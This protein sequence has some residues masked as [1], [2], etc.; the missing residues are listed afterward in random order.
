MTVHDAIRNANSLLPGTPV[1]VGEDPRWQA[2]IEIGQYLESQPQPVW[3]FICRWGA[4]PQ[5]DLRNAIASCLLEH[6]LEHHFLEYFPRVEEMVSAEPSFAYTF[7][8]CWQFGQAEEPDNSKR[9]QALAA[10]LCP[11]Q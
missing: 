2:I 9:W 3:E 8:Q 6:I 4:F 7:L 5:D 10:R 11:D 1:D